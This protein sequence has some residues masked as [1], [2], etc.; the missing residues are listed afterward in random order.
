ME[1]E[2]VRPR[3]IDAGQTARMGPC[4]AARETKSWDCAPAQAVARRE[5][6]GF[7]PSQ[8][9]RYPMRLHIPTLLAIGADMRRSRGSSAAAWKCLSAISQCTAADDGRLVGAYCQ[10]MHQKTINIE[11]EENAA[12]ANLADLANSNVHIHSPAS[13]V[14]IYGPNSLSWRIS[15]R[16]YQSGWLLFP[17]YSERMSATRTQSTASKA[18][19]K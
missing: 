4:R 19:P 10:A 12:T 11:S 7:P 1:A 9:I 13:V 3:D 2:V 5:A 6:T 18:L 8:K 14:S 17:E 15:S 16:R